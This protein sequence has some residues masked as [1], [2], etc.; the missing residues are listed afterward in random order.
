MRTDLDHLPEAKQEDLRRALEVIFSEF[1]DANSIANATWK[2]QARIDK[3]VLYGGHA[4]GDRA[5]DVPD[6]YSPTYDL[7][8]VVNHERLLDPNSDLWIRIDD[9]LRRDHA[10]MRRVSTRTNV[11]AR[12][13]KDV[14]FQLSRGR[15]F[16]IDIVRD[17]IMLYEVDER[18]FDTPAVLPPERALEEAQSYYAQWFATAGEFLDLARF[19]IGKGYRNRAA[20]Q[21][22]QATEQLYHTVLLVLKRWSPKSHNIQ[23]LRDRSE[24]VA[25]DLI[26]IWPGKSKFDN[27]CWELLRQAYVRGRYSPHYKITDAELAWLVERVDLLQSEVKRIA[28]ERIV[29]G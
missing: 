4:R 10:I 2:R 12:T 24:D 18:P 13:L 20:F 17:G 22:H 11:L 23:F 3:I 29:R 5:S 14:N 7:L 6:G 1:E 9:R 26:R 28:E 27:R 16:F 21:L 19:A 8:V 15:P 25:R